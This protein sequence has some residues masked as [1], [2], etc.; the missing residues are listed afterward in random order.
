MFRRRGYR[1]T[2]PV[3]PASNGELVIEKYT[4]TKTL[5]EFRDND[6][7]DLVPTPAGTNNKI[8]VSSRTLIL[9]VIGGVLLLSA[10]VALSRSFFAGAGVPAGAAITSIAVLPVKS[11]SEAA[12]DD[13]LRMRITD[14]LITRLGNIDRIAVRPTSAVLPF[15]D[16]ADDSLAIGQKLRVDAVIDS[17]LQSEGSKLRVTMQLIRVTTGEDLWS[18]QF[19]GEADKILELQDQIYA[20]VSRSL[21]AAGSDRAGFAKRPTQSSDAYEA[22]LKG[23]YFWADRDE[24]SLRKAIGYFEQAV[25]LDPQFS[26]A[27][28]GLADTKHLLFNYNIDVRPAIVEDAKNDL[29][30]ALELKPDSADALITLGTIQM[31]YDWDWAAAEASFK[32]A[33]AARAEFVACPRQIWRLFWSGSGNSTNRRLNSNALPSSTLYQ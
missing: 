30:R 13:E 10:A 20:K 19:D 31:G 25:A 15:A 3:H 21:N 7:N 5:I 27:Y 22:Y 18:G 11:F 33:I 6:T 12:D 26:E 16:S 2:F 28:S 14:A 24:A 17:R 1:F 9:S 23:R 8:R 32:R 4:S 29:R